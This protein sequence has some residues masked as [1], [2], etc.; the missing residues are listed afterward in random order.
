[1]NVRNVM[2]VLTLV[3][4]VGSGCVSSRAGNVYSRDQARTQQRVE[5]GTIEGIAD[6]MI[7]GTPGVVGAVA[8]GAMG[9]VLGST[10]GGGSGTDIAKTAGAIGG[11]AAGQAAE[12][13]VTKRAAW[14]FTVKLEA[15]RTIS[16]VQEK[17][18]DA[19][20]SVGEKVRVLEGPDGTMRV[21]K[22]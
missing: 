19:V 1:M 3:A 18:K 15:G 12:K 21:R 2:A 7:D 4:V 14:E 9:Y 8:G 10:V 5:F 13:V 20:Y 17:E 11:A 22:L 6:V 16:V